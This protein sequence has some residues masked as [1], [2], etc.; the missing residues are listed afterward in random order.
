MTGKIYRHYKGGLYKVICLANLE[1]N[2]EVM[3]VYISLD[4]VA[5]APWIRPLSEFREKFKEVQAN[6]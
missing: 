3:V 2:F 5:D 1:S 6:G 4:D